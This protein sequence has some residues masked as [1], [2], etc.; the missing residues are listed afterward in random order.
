MAYTF[1]RA[2][3]AILATSSTTA[4]AFLSN[5]F[6]PLM[7][8]SAFGY[9]AFIIVPV[10]YVLIILYFPAFLIIYE[11][12]IKEKEPVEEDLKYIFYFYRPQL[13]E[14]LWKLELEEGDDKNEK[15]KKCS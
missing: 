9:F 14:S 12:K 8:V 13:V 6:S 10:N 5:G 2:S 4:F 15:R 1:R 7:P 3:V 11:K